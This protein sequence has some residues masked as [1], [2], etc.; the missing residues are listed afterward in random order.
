MTKIIARQYRGD[1]D[2]D[3]NTVYSF[4]DNLSGGVVQVLNQ[5]RVFQQKQDSLEE[6]K[7]NILNAKCVLIVGKSGDLTRGQKKSLDLYRNNIKDVE[8]ITYD[9]LFERIK[10]LKEVFNY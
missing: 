1:D 2:L 5:R 7:V 10:A 9:E 6:S 4:S 3:H 8:I